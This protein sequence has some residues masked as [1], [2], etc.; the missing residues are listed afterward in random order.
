MNQA[1]IIVETIIKSGAIY[2]STEVGARCNTIFQQNGVS[3][4]LTK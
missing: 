3:L 2:E 4:V 1:Y